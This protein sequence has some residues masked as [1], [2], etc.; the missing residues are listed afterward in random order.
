[1]LVKRSGSTIIFVL[2]VMLIAMVITTTV[3]TVILNNV[4]TTTAYNEHARATFAMESGLERG[5]YYLQYARNA[6][7]IDATTGLATIADFT[8]TLSNASSYTLTT[9]FVSDHSY[10]L[11]Q[12]EVVQ[13]DVSDGS[14]PIAN[15]ANLAITW[16]ESSS[17]D[18]GLS[19]AEVSYSS[20]TE[21]TWIDISKPTMPITH[22]EVPC[23]GTAPVC[24][25]YTL[26]VDSNYLYKVRVKAMTCPITAV[27]VTPLDSGGLP[28]TL[29][30][31]VQID[32][33]GTYA[34][35]QSQ[36]SVTA[37]WNTT[38]NPYLDFVLF[39]EQTVTK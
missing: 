17:C 38:L 30:N 2:M 7:T 32:S 28:L 21:D 16:V 4:R 19:H 24:D 14:Q 29:K 6:K 10:D 35:S 27:L 23:T 20:W 9:S 31:Y 22:Y 8:S 3:V 37:P 25:G 36:G 33:T 39:S 15:M 18:A 1:M 5:L 34:K 12:N 26:E 13:W 11:A